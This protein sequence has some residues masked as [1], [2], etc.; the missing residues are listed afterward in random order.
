MFGGDLGHAHHPGPDTAVAPWLAD[1]ETRVG[2]ERAA[3]VMTTQTRDLL[4]P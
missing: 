4:L 3:A 1:L 2:A